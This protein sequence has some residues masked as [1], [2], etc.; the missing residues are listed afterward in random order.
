MSSKRTQPSTAITRVRVSGA[1][2]YLQQYVEEDKSLALMKDLV[3][4]PRVKVIQPMTD[5]ELK[6]RFGEGS[7][8]VRPG[9]RLICAVNEA[10]RFQPLFFFSEFCRWSDRKDKERPM[11][12]DRTFDPTSTLAKRAGD[13][14]LRFE[15]YE[16]DRNKPADKQRKFRYVHHLCFIGLLLG[17]HPLAGTRMTVSFQR[18]EFPTGRSLISSISLR[19][20]PLW[21]QIWD[22]SPRLRERA[23]NKWFGLDFMM[24]EDSES[25]VSEE[26]APAARDAHLE[27][28]QLHEEKRLRVDHQE[29][30]ETE[31][32]SGAAEM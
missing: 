17:D 29:L 7:A 14:E 23:D 31:G 15:V 18:G 13:P 20:L 6:G 1:P 5:T 4:V 30:D 9:D 16:E 19:K 11:I 21:A 32:E 10:F 22:F 26:S 12:T 27:L 8:I 2:A 28:A 3:I 25:V 24:P